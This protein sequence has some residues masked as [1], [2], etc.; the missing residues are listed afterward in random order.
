MAGFTGHVHR[1]KTPTLSATESD[2]FQLDAATCWAH[3]AR[4][5]LNRVTAG[6]CAGWSDAAE[7]IARSI[8]SAMS[9]TLDI[10][11]IF[12]G[13]CCSSVRARA[14]GVERRGTGAGRALLASRPHSRRTEGGARA[15]CASHELLNRLPTAPLATDL[16]YRH[17]V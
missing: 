6:A 3:S 12:F 2:A 15:G 17:R 9:S 10:F 14:R 7:L 11:L 16:H 8:D 13:S 5:P 1:E 4:C